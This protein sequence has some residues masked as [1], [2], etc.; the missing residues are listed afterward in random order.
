ML[1]HVG[2]EV[3]DKYCA[4]YNSSSVVYAR[5]VFEKIG[6]PTYADE[7]PQDKKFVLPFGAYYAC[8][9]V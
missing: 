9:H 2:D 4:Q 5:H 7:R 6:V 3:V 1:H 8:L